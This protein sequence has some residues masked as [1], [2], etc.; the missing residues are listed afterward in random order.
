MTNFKLGYFLELIPMNQ[1]DATHGMVLIGI[2]E[3]I[4][5]PDLVLNTGYGTARF[6]L[7]ENEETLVGYDDGKQWSIG[8]IL[9]PEGF[10]PE[11]PA[12]DPML[13]EIHAIATKMAAELP[14]AVSGLAREFHALLS[15]IAE[16]V[17]NYAPD[18]AELAPP[19]AELPAIDTE[20]GANLPAPPKPTASARRFP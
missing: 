19:E 7:D 2:I 4:A 20:P 3:Q 6:R 13:S 5:Q 10:S 11:P 16:P 14:A 12:P 18:P 17:K 8:R 15:H 1:P 9:L